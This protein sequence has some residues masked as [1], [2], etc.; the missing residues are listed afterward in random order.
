MGETFGFL[1]RIHSGSTQSSPCVLTAA[2]CW[3]Q[4][5][6]SFHSYPLITFTLV[7]NKK[8]R[9]MSRAKQ[10]V[11]RVR[12]GPENCLGKS[13]RKPGVNNRENWNWETRSLSPLVQWT[14]DQVVFTH[15]TEFNFTPCPVQIQWSLPTCTDDAA[16]GE[17]AQTS[18]PRKLPAA[19]G[20]SRPCRFTFPARSIYQSI[21]PWCR[22]LSG[23][24]MTFTKGD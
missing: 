13:S 15:Q 12:K 22:C 21:C 17:A 6:G 3:E 1:R 2:P 11:G 19:S 8:G 4:L 16:P 14:L 24:V 18:C 20:I 7:E 23:T 10:A 9:V 5:T